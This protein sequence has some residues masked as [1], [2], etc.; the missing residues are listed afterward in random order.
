MKPMPARGGESFLRDGIAIKLASGDGFVNSSQVLIDNAASA[1]IEMTDFR[2]AHLTFGQANVRAAGTQL[3]AG[4]VAIELI[5][6]WR[7]GEQ[8]SIAV[9]LRFRFAAWINAPAVAN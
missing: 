7:P 8:T 2:V 3:T 5:V 4:I 6:K 1:E 9:F